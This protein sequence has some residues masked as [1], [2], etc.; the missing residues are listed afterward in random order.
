MRRQ[1]LQTVLHGCSAGFIFGNNPIWSFSA[2]PADSFYTG[3]GGVPE[4]TT[5]LDSVGSQSAEAIG[6]LLES[7]D[8]TLLVP[9]SSA[10]IIT[11]A[12]GADATRKVCAYTSD[13][14]D[15]LA[16]IPSATSTT[17]DLSQ[18]NG[19]NVLVRWYDPIDQSYTADNTYSA[20]GSQ[21]ISH[22]GNNSEGDSDW[23]LVMESVS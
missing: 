12:L 19:P 7:I 21:A 11:S 16:Y 22:P 20:S 14:A 18:F 9:D 2:G 17:I 4:W 1:I 6:V 13:G 3:G 23:V 5:V 10:A 15:A 8:W